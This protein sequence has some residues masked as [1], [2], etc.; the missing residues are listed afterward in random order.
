MKIY[1]SFDGIA[2]CVR[3]HG[4]SDTLAAWLNGSFCGAQKQLHFAAYNAWRII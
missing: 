3:T 1:A 4:G 2:F